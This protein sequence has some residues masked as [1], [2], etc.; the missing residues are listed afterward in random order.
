MVEVQYGDSFTFLGLHGENFTNI[1]K[2][3]IM[4]ENIEAPVES[5]DVLGYL[6]YRLDGQEIG[7]VEILAAQN[8]EKA[9]FFDY[10]K[11]IWKMVT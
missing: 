1:E 4:Q 6:V 8:V 5:G 3:V 10:S 2:E 11:K 7:R 9:G